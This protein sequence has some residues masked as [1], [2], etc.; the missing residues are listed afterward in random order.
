MGTSFGTSRRRPLD[1]QYR[2][3]NVPDVTSRG[4]PED[5]PVPTGFGLACGGRRGGSGVGHIYLIICRLQVLCK[6]E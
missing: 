3:P 5:G 6:S 1:V 4:R 2:R